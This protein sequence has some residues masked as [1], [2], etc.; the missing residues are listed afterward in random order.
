MDFAHNFSVGKTRY[1]DLTETGLKVKSRVREFCAFDGDDL[2]V[3]RELDGKTF[4]KC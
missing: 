3:G 2:S 4:E 1:E